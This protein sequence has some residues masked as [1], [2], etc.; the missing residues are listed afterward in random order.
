MH[1]LMAAVLLGMTGFDAFNSNPQPEP[2][3]SKFA[4]VKQGVSRS[5]G[6][7]VVTANVDRQAAL[8]K[9]PLKHSKSVIFAGGR[10]S[11]TGEEKTASV[12]SDGQWIAV[13]MITQP[14]LALVV[15][16]PQLIRLLA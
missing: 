9:K 15:G 10:K 3:D 6:H 12:I 11:L 1:A 13:L 8:L 4:Q 2:P 16:A 7:A 5:E 14:E